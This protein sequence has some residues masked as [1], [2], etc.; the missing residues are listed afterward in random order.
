M[1]QNSSF[2][3]NIYDQ[4]PQKP[5]YYRLRKREVNFGFGYIAQSIV[6]SLVFN[7]NQIPLRLC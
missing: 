5:I 4:K 7:R 6:C 1:A 2:K 3:G